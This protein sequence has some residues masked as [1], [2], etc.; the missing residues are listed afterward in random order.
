MKSLGEESLALQLRA[1]NLHGWERE[2]R[3]DPVRRW[4]FDFAFEHRKF[5]IEIEGGSWIG[6]RHSR[7]GG[8][9]ADQ[10]KYEAAMLA[11]WTVYRCTTD[12][13]TSGHAISV[14]QRMVA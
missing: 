11:G 10:E 1:I 8:F 6:G 3:F 7:G 14:I 2:Y 13:V 9:E 12:T 5:A 4:R